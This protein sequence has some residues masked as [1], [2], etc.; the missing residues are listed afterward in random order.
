MAN[1]KDRMNAQQRAAVIAGDGP[2]LVLAGPGSGKTRVLTSRI[3]YLVRLRQVAPQRIM[4]VTFTNKATDEMRSRLERMLGDDL[5]G[6]HIG[7]FHRI[8]ARLLRREAELL[9]FRPGWKILATNRQY[10]VIR[11]ILEGTVRGEAPISPGKARKAI[12]LAKNRMIL[13]EMFEETDEDSEAVGR[14]YRAYQ[15]E[16]LAE[17]LM[18]VDDLLLQLGILLREFPAARHK[19]QSELDFLLIDEFQDT[20]LAQYKIVKALAPPQNNIY[21]VGDEDQSVYAFRGANYRN[22][23]RLRSDFPQ[24]A[25][26]LLEEN[27][28]STQTILDAAR[29]VIKHN[30]H[31]THK[32]LFSKN[33]VGNRIQVYDAASELDEAEYAQEQ[34]EL[35]R[36][37]LRLR[38]GDFA[39]MYRKHVQ[40]L[41]F[42][43]VFHLHDV[44]FRV[45]N[46]ID[47][48]QRREVRDI[49][50]LMHLAQ[51]SDSVENFRRLAE[52]RTFGIS[53]AGMSAF[54]EWLASG[55]M[56]LVEALD[57]VETGASPVKRRQ[58]KALAGCASA[59]KTWRKNAAKGN[60]ASVFEQIYRDAKYEQHLKRICK[61]DWELAERRNS[62]ERL[63]SLA[64][65][66]STQSEPFERF[67]KLVGLE[68]GDTE[69]DAD[70]V[71]LTTLHS[72]KGL[73]FPV[74]FIAGLNQDI[75]PHVHDKDGPND[76]TEERRLFYVGITRAEQ[77]LYLT[78]AR[79]KGLSDKTL[80]PSEFLAE[81]PDHLIELN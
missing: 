62:V 3:A 77:R 5:D 47:F 59:L 1:S 4:A 72:A 68:T 25:E 53:K 52:F 40:S 31:R 70:K 69:D 6:M 20:N 28:R 23:Q 19:F 38:Y 55:E 12:S 66:L 64:S 79:K 32:A 22:L 36:D 13:P 63:R 41:P 65:A 49:M 57:Q 61:D 7:T 14:V 54:L 8:A 44:P 78:Y 75:L 17:N 42:K 48:D 67:V 24:L 51:G 45:V 74:V 81:L 46:A 56:G 26:F 27:Y 33:G 10:W 80:A 21:A 9:G 11:R 39:V 50:A 30:P 35:L 73:E 29:A 2:V 76:V 15:A 43:S 16:L 58:R 34:I 18:D 71:A 37:S 60:L